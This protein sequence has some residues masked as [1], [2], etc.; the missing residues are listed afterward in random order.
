MKIEKYTC[1]QYATWLKLN[2]ILVSLML[3][4]MIESMVA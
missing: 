1:T 2:Y 4:T 3:A